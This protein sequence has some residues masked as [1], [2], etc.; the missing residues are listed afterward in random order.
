MMKN[1]RKD[2]ERMIR[3]RGWKK[4]EYD[5]DRIREILTALVTHA[6]QESL[7]PNIQPLFEELHRLARIGPPSL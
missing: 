7:G 1:F 5:V 6:E 4:P 2:V 3:R